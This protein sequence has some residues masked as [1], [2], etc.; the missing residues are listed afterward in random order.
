M[1]HWQWL[2]LK[3]KSIEESK[4]IEEP[5][6]FEK[7]FKGNIEHALKEKVE[8]KLAMKNGSI[9]WL[10]L[11]KESIDARK[12][13]EIV[14]NYTVDFT[15]EKEINLGRKIG[16]KQ[17][18]QIISFAPNRNYED[19]KSG[20]FPLNKP[21]VVVGFGPSG[22]LAGLL[23]AERGLNPIIIERGKCAKERSEDVKNFWNNKVLNR[24]SNVQFGAGGAGTFSDGKLTTGIKDL[25]IRKVLEELVEAGSPL[26]ILYKQKPH[27]G[28][29][30]LVNVVDRIQDKIEALGGKIF[31]STRLEEVLIEKSE[32]NYEI[33]GCRVFRLE[34]ESYENIYTDDV[35]LATGHSAR[36]TFQMLYDKGITMEQKPFSMGVRIE[37]SQELIDMSQYG[38]SGLLPVAD[39]KLNHKCENGRG[40][41]TFCMC[42]GGQVIMSA[43]LENT[44]V[45]NGMSN[46]NRDS[47][48]ANSGLLCD[49][50]TSDFEDDHPLAG[51][52]FQ[53]K[54]ER[55]AFINGG[56]NY[57]PPKC[58]WE[59]L[60]KGSKA[61]KPL[62][63]SLPEFV[64]DSIVEAMPHIGRKLKG[65]DS[66]DA[67][68]TGIETRSSSPVRFSRDEEFRAYKEGLIIEG[69]YPCG[70]GAG[71][72]GGIMS[73]SCDGIKIA[74]RII[75]RYEAQNK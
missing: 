9:G 70:E 10:T 54:Y 59:D 41:Y 69:L 7:I 56:S 17:V 40:V 48:I 20:T 49:I 32:N 68:L 30:V 29:D 22:M 24:E 26:D 51:A 38:S 4:S 6:A 57:N 61:S 34:E 55:L 28:T 12:K 45:T 3:E 62:V 8:K 73:A 46:R 16:K 35:I 27:I 71:Y 18:G 74:E 64:V 11:I 60:S 14:F 13:S 44:V 66:G 31:Y 75:G 43:S 65:F 50:R 19:V 5:F 47:G 53:E 58:T 33:K 67:V 52:K 72:A 63:Y 36:D 15:I 37:H 23:L 39:Y 42:P 1:P 21:P 25:R 2:D